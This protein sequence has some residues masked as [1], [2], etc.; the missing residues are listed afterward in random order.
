MS[1]S[2]ERRSRVRQS[3]NI[4][5]TVVSDD[6]VTRLEGR[7]RNVSAGGA[8]LELA[9]GHDV[10]SSFYMLLPD[11]RLQPCSIVWNADGSFGLAFEADEEN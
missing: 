8:R 4:E 10:P 7:I 11:H 1:F 2:V 5:A 3:V 9:S 6:G